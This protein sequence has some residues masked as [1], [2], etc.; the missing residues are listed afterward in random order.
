[1]RLSIEG[2]RRLERVA[3]WLEQGAPHEILD[4]G[5]DVRWFCMDVGV[6]FT[7]CGA[8]CCVAGAVVEFNDPYDVDLIR[9]SRNEAGEMPWDSVRDRAMT[10]LGLDPYS[11]MESQFA[12]KLFRDGGTENEWI[13]AE[14]AAQVLRYY[15]ETGELD[16]EKFQPE[17]Y[18][19]DTFQRPPMAYEDW[20]PLKLDDSDEDDD[21]GDMEDL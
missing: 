16:W 18:D 19:P 10:L 3:R 9:A 5:M 13:T 2:R 20:G 17:D 7:E 12:T 14:I 1:M 15:L 8:V 4:N 21:E 6:N 11:A